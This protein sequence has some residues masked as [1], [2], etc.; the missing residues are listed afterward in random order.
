M[1][2]YTMLTGKPPFYLGGTD[3]NRRDMLNMM[4]RIKAGSFRVDTIEWQYISEEA[5]NLIKGMYLTPLNRRKFHT[6]L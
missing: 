3:H 4:R 2:Q 6:R 5:K 1:L